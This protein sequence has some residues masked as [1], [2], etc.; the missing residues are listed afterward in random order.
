MYVVNMLYSK[1]EYKLL[2]LDYICMLYVLYKY[3]F[4]GGLHDKNKCS[5]TKGWGR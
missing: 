4:K 5:Y 1:V 3:D 2:I